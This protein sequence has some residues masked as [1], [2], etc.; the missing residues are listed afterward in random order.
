MDTFSSCIHVSCQR[1]TGLEE[2]TCFTMGHVMHVLF[3]FFAVFE[4]FIASF[5]SDNMLVHAL[6]VF[7]ERAT[8]IG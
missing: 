4:N 3:V 5:S 6:D 1:Q 8:E 7:N 2:N